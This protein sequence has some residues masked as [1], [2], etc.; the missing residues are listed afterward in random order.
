[1]ICSATLWSVLEHVSY[2]SQWRRGLDDTRAWLTESY[3]YMF[4]YE[5]KKNGK[6]CSFFYKHQVHAKHIGRAATKYDTRHGRALQQM[7]Q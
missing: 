2:K 6:E 5:Q 4:L 1:M 3:T 7:H